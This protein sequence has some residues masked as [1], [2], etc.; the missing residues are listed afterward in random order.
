[1]N[2]IIFL[3]IALLLSGCGVLPHAPDA[4]IQ[5]PD[6]I[7][8]K[9]PIVQP[10]VTEDVPLPELFVGKLTDEDAADPGKVVQ[11]YAADLTQLKG[12]VLRQKVLLNACRDGTL[13][14][15]AVAPTDP[16]MLPSAAVRVPPATAP[17]PT[18]AAVAPLVTEP[19]PTPKPPKP[20]SATRPSGR[21]FAPPPP[22]Q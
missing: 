22:T 15:A 20:N 17:E 21:T 8:V 6:P 14:P 9:V 16:P 3:V 18:P 2:K 4:V 13:P 12:V 11:Y 1:M 10:C 5:K 7:I 19:T